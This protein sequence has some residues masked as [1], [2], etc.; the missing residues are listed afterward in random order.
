MLSTAGNLPH[1]TT[2]VF[3]KKNELV[4]AEGLPGGGQVVDSLQAE[5]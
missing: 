2:Q 5:P 1:R 4:W 3:G